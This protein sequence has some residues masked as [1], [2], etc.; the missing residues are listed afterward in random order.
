MVKRDTGACP[1][2]FGVSPSSG[3]GFLRRYWPHAACAAALVCAFALFALT[4]DRYGVYTPLHVDQPW[5]NE[6]AARVLDGGDFR[7]LLHSAT[8]YRE[9]V[10]AGHGPFFPR[11]QVLVLRCLGVNQFACRI[12]SYLAGHMATVVIVMLLLRNRLPLAA[13]AV[14]VFSVGDTAVVQ[15]LLGRPDGLSR[16]FVAIAFACL[17]R[18]VVVSSARWLWAVGASLGLAVGF[19]PVT[20]C[21][22]LA[23][24]LVLPVSFPVRRW[25]SALL[26]I[27][28]GGLLPLALVFACWMPHPLLGAKQFVWGLQNVRLDTSLHERVQ[29]LMHP[30]PEHLLHYALAG[31]TVFLLPIIVRRLRPCATPVGIAS[32]DATLFLA[33]VFA[34]AGLL[35]CAT[36]PPICHYYLLF[37]TP[38]PVVAGAVWIEGHYRH[39]RLRRRCQTVVVVAML[40]WVP[41]LSWNVERCIDSV[42]LWPRLDRA[43]MART[44]SECVPAEAAVYGAPVF[45]IIIRDARRHFLPLSWYADDPTLTTDIPLRAWLVLNGEYL[46][47]FNRSNPSAL[48]GRQLVRSGVCFPGLP[49]RA[50]HYYIFGP[51][52]GR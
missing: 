23:A 20:A 4:M 19:H 11:M 1:V 51:C 37:F 26:S 14:A 21:F 2:E 6:P 35:I 31:V 13:V 15:L 25:G 43:S 22:G 45:F 47:Y 39:T 49:F 33:A 29:V 38:W 40:C 5:F 46:E 12:P 42:A 28:G 17:V 3:V 34:A 24:V 27:A 52:G 16:L 50:G 30:Q 32:R 41:F 18:A 48:R 10:Q 9:C 44:V 7:L 36:Q 8:P